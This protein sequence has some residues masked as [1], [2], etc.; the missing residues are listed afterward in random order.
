MPLYEAK[1]VHYFDHRWATYNGVESRDATGIEHA[2]PTWEPARRYW[3]PQNDIKVLLADKGWSHSWLLGWRDI[4]RATDERTMI[5]VTIPH[6][7]IGNKLPV[8]FHSL[9][10]RLNVQL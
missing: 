5:A 1:M 2:D 9:L 3:V 4:A 7:A 6:T 8:F 10:N